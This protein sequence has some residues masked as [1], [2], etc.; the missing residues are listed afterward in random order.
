MLYPIESCVT[1][2]LKRH[3]KLLEKNI[4][5]S[6]TESNMQQFFLYL[7]DAQNSSSIPYIILAIH[8]IVW[9]HNFQGAKWVQ[10]AY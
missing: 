4:S 1:A 5:E 10:T 2:M 7:Q 3:K 9:S 6:V 8:I